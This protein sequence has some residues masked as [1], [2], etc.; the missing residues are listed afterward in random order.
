[1]RAYV[2]DVQHQAES[3]MA[4][5]R[6]ELSAV[7]SESAAQMRHLKGQLAK[8]RVSPGGR[9]SGTHADPSG[10]DASRAA[11]IVAEA[12]LGSLHI[13]LQEAQ[14]AL[15]GASTSLEEVQAQRDAAVAANIASEQAI[16]ALQQRCEAAESSTAS[17]KQIVA[18]LQDSLHASD[19]TH[20]A[21]LQAGEDEVR[22]LMEAV[23][24]ME[25][26]KGEAEREAN[27]LRQLCTAMQEARGAAQAAVEEL[28]QQLA[29]AQASKVKDD[30]AAETQIRKLE[31]RL[32]TAA[33][34]KQVSQH[35]LQELDTAMAAASERETKLLAELE[36]AQAEEASL[37]SR[38]QAAKSAEG[39][40]SAHAQALQEQVTSHWQ[41]IQDIAKESGE[42]RRMLAEGKSEIEH[43]N[44]KIAFAQR[45]AEEG[46]AMHAEEMQA[47][48][49]CMST[50]RKEASYAVEASEN[51]RKEAEARMLAQVQSCRQ[52]AEVAQEHAEQLVSLRMKL[53]EAEARCQSYASKHAGAEAELSATRAS[54]EVL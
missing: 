38:L 45:E 23:N 47:L 30:T 28:Q 36:A 50:L 27:R 21:A 46:K 26:D 9:R 40:S 1:M 33:A 48:Q 17:Q 7:R 31:E 2:Q 49:S 52:T 51:A 24:A 15:A 43:L 13:A 39:E 37:K 44:S 20:M 4:K 22:E 32:S 25:D 8:V 53:Q 18:T 41:T 29:A 19:S 35:H 5:M 10:S 34:K 16:A 54:A 14:Q 11:L 6:A 12:E 42:A 3:R